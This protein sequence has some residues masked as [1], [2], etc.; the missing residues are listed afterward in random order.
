MD[1]FI[2]RWNVLAG[3][4]VVERSKKKRAICRLVLSTDVLEKPVED[5]V[6]DILDPGCLL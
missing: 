2:H 3:G 4:E 5:S 6:Q 1:V